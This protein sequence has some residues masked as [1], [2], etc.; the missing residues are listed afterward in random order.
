MTLGVVGDEDGKVGRAWIMEGLVC[1]V[2]QVRKAHETKPE[3]DP[4]V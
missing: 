1:N 2:T 4:M 3:K